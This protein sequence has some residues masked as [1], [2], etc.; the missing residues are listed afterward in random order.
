MAGFFKRAV[1]QKCAVLQ[2]TCAVLMENCAIR[3]HAIWW[4]KGVRKRIA[5]K[6]VD[7]GMK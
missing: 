7:L 1:P 5:V 3:M 2:K 6:M 4:P